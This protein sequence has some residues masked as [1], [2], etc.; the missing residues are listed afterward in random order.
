[1]PTAAHP[2]RNQGTLIFGDRTAN[3][4]HQLVMRVLTHRAIQK[5]DLTAVAFQFFN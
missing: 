3:L 4:Q 5:L 1:V 2:V